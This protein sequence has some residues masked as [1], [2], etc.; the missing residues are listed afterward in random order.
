MNTLLILLQSSMVSRLGEALLHFLWQGAVVAAL[1]AAALHGTRRHPARVRYGLSCGALAVMAVLPLASMVL[2]AS[3]AAEGRSL[4][5]AMAGTTGPDLNATAR[6]LAPGWLPWVTLAWGAGV[7]GVGGR[8]A[9]G[10]RR[11]Q[12]L[13]TVSVRP[14]PSPWPQRLGELQRR[15]GVT[16]RVELLES[17]IARVPMVMGWLRPVILLPMGLVTGMPP[18]HVE[19]ILA[20]E[21]AHL[22]RRD[23]LVNLLQCVV[24]T[25]LFYHPAVR[26]V[27]ERIRIEREFCCDDLAAT[28]INDRTELA[29]ALV[30]LAEQESAA[31]PAFAFAADGGSVTDRVRRLLGAPVTREGRGWLRRLCCAVGVAVLLA[32]G[33]WLGLRLTAPRLYVSTAR[34]VVQ[35]NRDGEQTGFPPKY[36]PYFLQSVMRVMASQTVLD[37]VATDLGL[38]TRWNIQEPESL[39]RRLGERLKVRQYRDT[40]ILEVAAASENSQ[41]ASDIAN[42]VARQSIAYSDGALGSA[43]DRPRRELQAKV[44][45]CKRRLNALQ[46]SDNPNEVELKVYE[47]LLKKL[48]TQLAVLEIETPGVTSAPFVEMID[49]AEPA[50][51]RRPWRN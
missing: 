5:V 24:E 10:W 27:S 44:D 12:R 41:E 18:A 46:L 15:L 39:T 40:A 20:H 49:P 25:L 3:G 51:R 42:S 2:L 1:L 47:E 16:G 14:V 28:V 26:W 6:P 30:A 33:V 32:G 7:V 13:R 50:L 48:L 45:R 43:R 35:D 9:G 37:H 31:A 17:G 22:R 36:A 11:I 29:G 34:I 23:Y 8:F 19:A 38:A 21:L 4:P